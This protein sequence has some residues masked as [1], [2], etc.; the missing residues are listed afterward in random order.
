M[1][2]LLA[3]LPS[4]RIDGRDVPGREQHQRLNSASSSPI[5]ENVE[6]DIGTHANGRTSPAITP[7]SAKWK[8]KGKEVVRPQQPSGTHS[9]DAMQMTRA[10]EEEEESRGL[11]MSNS[12][13]TV[14]AYPPMTD[15]DV[16]AAKIEEVRRQF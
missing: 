2:A 7:T 15:E 12:D 6:M 5:V 3:Q 4:L 13:P 16:E 1:T 9:D 8:G 14:G 10:E 11:T